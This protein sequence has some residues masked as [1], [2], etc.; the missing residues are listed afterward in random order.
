M[1]RFGYMV[2]TSNGWE[3]PHEKL[4]LNLVDCVRHAIS[5]KCIVTYF[6]I[7]SNSRII[8]ELHTE[9][10][11]DQYGYIILHLMPPFE[12]FTICTHSTKFF[13]N[14]LDGILEC[15]TIALDEI[16][17]P[18]FRSRIGYFKKLSSDDIMKEL[19]M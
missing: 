7:M 11:D 2:E 8:T 13:T 15:K 5:Q 3:C 16:D 6:K 1:E 4:F 10:S 9:S 17:H 18:S 12:Y 19:H 14:V